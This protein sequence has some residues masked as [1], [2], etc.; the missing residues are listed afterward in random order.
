MWLILELSIRYDFRVLKQTF[1][2]ISD[3]PIHPPIKE[4]DPFD[5]KMQDNLNFTMKMV[6]GVMHVYESK[7]MAEQGKPIE[8]P[9]PDRLSYLS[10]LNLM[11][12]LISD[13]PLYV[14][15]TSLTV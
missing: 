15:S 13:G 11:L 14:T 3:F 6:D 5:V 7:A 10:E 8:L 1:R 12:A 2:R 9:Y 4:G